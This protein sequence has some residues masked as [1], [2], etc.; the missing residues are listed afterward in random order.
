VSIPAV[1]MPSAQLNITDTIT[2]TAQSEVTNTTA[3]LRARV[4]YIR[5]RNA[6]TGYAVLN[7]DASD[8]EAKVAALSAGVLADDD[9]GDSVSFTAVGYLSAVREGDEYALSG[10]WV[11][12]R[13]YGLQYQFDSAEVVLPAGRE[14]VIAYLSD[15]SYG[16]GPKKA[17]RIVDLLGEDCL[18]RLMDYD[19][20]DKVDGEGNPSAGPRLLD[21]CASF[22][23]EQQCHEIV[24]H[25]EDNYSLA[26]L[27][28]LICRVPGVTPKL[29][30]RISAK[31]GHN[32]ASLV[33]ENP[34][35]LTRIHGIGFLTADKVAHAVGIAPDAP[36]RVE[37]AIEY[38]IDEAT[39]NEGHCFLR[40]R[41]IAARLK[42]V[43]GGVTLSTEQMGMACQKM[44]DAGQ[45]VRED[46][47]ADEV[48]GQAGF[49]AVYVASL[50][51][52][53]T[54]VATRIGELISTPLPLD[55]PR[56][57]SAILRAQESV[58][59]TYNDTQQQAIRQ[60][61]TSRFSVVTGP[62][63]SGKTTVMRSVVEAYYAMDSNKPIYLASPTGR[64]AKRL[65]EATGM[66]AQTI[67]RLLSYHPMEGF[68]VNG[69]APLEP[70]LLCVDE[71]SMLDCELMAHLM[72][73]ITPDMQV[74]L[75]GDADQLPSVGP[76]SVLRDIIRSNVVPTTRLKFV[77]RQ[78]EGSEIHLWAS[79]IREGIV[80]ALVSGDDVKVFKARDGAAAAQHVIELAEKAKARGLSPMDVQFLSPV[81][82]SE[83]GVNNLNDRIREILNPASPNNA[84]LTGANPEVRGFRVGDK[85][86]VVKND[87]E[88]MVY[89]GD[90]GMVV[91][92]D[93][94]K[95]SVTVDIDGNAIEIDDDEKRAG[96]L[97]L[98]Y[99]TTVH[100]SQGGEFPW[101]VLVLTR[102]AY[103][104]LNREVVY[105]AITRARKRLIVVCDDWAMKK[106]VQNGQ[107]QERYSRLAERLRAQVKQQQDSEVP[108]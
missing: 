16:V 79:D 3:T 87:Y 7:M 55:M 103:M 31:L 13:R 94:Q 1:E 41:D 49:S 57:D 99:C 32:A 72:D 17:E 73:G 27:T 12:D 108:F 68:R 29:A 76:G 69:E 60:A 78:A 23:T 47:P 61:L 56:V 2:D 96:I 77:Y 63:G 6:D 14:G 15:I 93:P 58:G 106:A 42:D 101:V 24:Q 104:L 67:H 88:L 30:A 40:P 64:A 80:P 65:S 28:S 9:A 37:A 51:K 82:K 39:S 44:I 53:E 21:R 74:V 59:I 38:L 4:A 102:Q 10:K 89:N 34:Y 84:D 54:E 26:Q 35:I 22:L 91:G 46:Y 48:T 85:V 97:K 36:M 5:Y 71:V 52:A 70:G 45:L 66:E 107:A 105:T 11:T 81:Y 43:L 50:H 25:L 20:A 98:A 95:R 90:L 86:L 33:A 19:N 8:N 83:S 92:V 75:V 18:S 62:P 100:K